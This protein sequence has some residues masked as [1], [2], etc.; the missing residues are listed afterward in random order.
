MIMISRLI[1]R[2]CLSYSLHAR[3]HVFSILHHVR[4]CV[5]HAQSS[6][7]VMPCDL[8]IS[9]V[10]SWQLRVHVLI[11]TLHVQT[12][13]TMSKH[14]SSILTMSKHH[15][16]YVLFGVPHVWTSK[17]LRLDISCSICLLEEFFYFLSCKLKRITTRFK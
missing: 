17:M 14:W 12:S 4:T 16:E 3:E 2:S 10:M 8:G 13:P 1:S 11:K 9:T 7:L 6:L 15:K 5:L